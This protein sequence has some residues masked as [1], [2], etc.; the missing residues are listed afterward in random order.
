[1]GVTLEI[2]AT[3]IQT[4]LAMNRLGGQRIELCTAIELGGLTPNYGL[5]KACVQHTSLVVFVMIRHQQGGFVYHNQDIE[6]MLNDIEMTGDAQAHGVVFGCLTTENNINIEQNKRLI[7]KAKKHR[8]GTTFHR[9][10][11]YCKDPFL[12]LEQIIDLGFDRIL[13]SGQQETAIIGIDLIEK[14]V[15]QAK[16]RIEIMAG[17]GVNAANAQ[18]II[19][20]GIDALHFTVCKKSRIRSN[21]GMGNRCEVDENKIKSVIEILKPIK[22]DT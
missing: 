12:A 8:L 17:S 21:L 14:L 4:A 11:D 7:E 13:T 5:I 16:G 2:C 1:M 10:F 20:T 3:T 18:T 22:H 9:A 19:N 6:V 15:L